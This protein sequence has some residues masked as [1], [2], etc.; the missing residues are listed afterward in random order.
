[1]SA[2]RPPLFQRVAIIGLGLIGGSLAAAIREQGLAL[3][4]YWVFALPASRGWRAPWWPAPA[5]R[6]PWSR[7]WPWG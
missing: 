3:D 6:A 7:A 2:H 1:M 5:P 4:M